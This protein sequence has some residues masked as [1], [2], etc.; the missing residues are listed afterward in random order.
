[1]PEISR[2]FGIRVEMFYDDHSP[3]HFHARHEGDRAAFTLEGALLQGTLSS[4]A[5]RLIVEWAALHQAELFK[6]WELAENHLPL[7]RIPPLP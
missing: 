2:F 6:N 1:M 7:Q 3:P 4:Q 5:Q